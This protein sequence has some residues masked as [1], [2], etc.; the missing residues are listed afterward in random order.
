MFFVYIVECSD[1]S[2]YTGYTNDLKKRVEKHNKGLASK[3]TRSR[4]PVR[5]V[6]KK[7]SKNKSY[8]MKTEI[9]IKGL[10]RREKQRLITG[11][12]L[13]NLLRKYTKSE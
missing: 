8:A 2:Y 1:K 12:R 13:D 7:R 3:Y 5:L 10:P 11:A 4:L 9:K 6:W